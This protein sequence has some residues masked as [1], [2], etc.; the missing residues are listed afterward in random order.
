MARSGSSL[1]L[2]SVSV[3]SPQGIDWR[4]PA[5]TVSSR[6]ASLYSIHGFVQWACLAVSFQFPRCCWLDMRIRTSFPLLLPQLPLP[7][8]LR[9]PPRP[10]YWA[11]IHTFLLPSLPYFFSYWRCALYRPSLEIRRKGPLSTLDGRGNALGDR[12]SKMNVRERKKQEVHACLL[13]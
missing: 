4:R 1:S 9:E 5:C 12:S 10:A 8:T 13:P 2:Q 7:C 6:M 11:H 3:S